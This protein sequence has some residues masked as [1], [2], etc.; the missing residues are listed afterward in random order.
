MIGNMEYGIQLDSIR[1]AKVN[2]EEIYSR[3][4]RMRL[5]APYLGVSKMLGSASLAEEDRPT[6]RGVNLRAASALS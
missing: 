4:L 6:G 1:R 3:G 2:A 5:C